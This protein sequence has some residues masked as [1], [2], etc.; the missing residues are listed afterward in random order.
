MEEQ[1]KQLHKRITD[2]E[3]KILQ[4]SD[5]KLNNSRSTNIEKIATALSKAQGK[6]PDADFN[7]I[8]HHQKYANLYAIIKAS[9]LTLETH[10][11][12]VTQQINTD[13]NGK[14]YLQTLLMHESG[15]WIESKVLLKPTADTTQGFGA[16]VT[17]IC[18]YAYKALVGII[19][20]DLEDDDGQA[21]TDKEEGVQPLKEDRVELITKDQLDELNYMLSGHLDLVGSIK[22]KLKI[23]ELAYIYKEEYR[24]VVNFINTAKQA[25]INAKAA[26]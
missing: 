13:E 8:G 25:K 11:L 20:D 6:M 2:L 4:L 1:I 15:Q 17:Y 26:E 7:R 19:A 23:K 22:R 10:G 18:R 14:N 5:T 21:A 9:R 3:I 24:D 16:A 12:S